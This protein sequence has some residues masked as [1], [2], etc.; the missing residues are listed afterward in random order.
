MKYVE[1]T[2]P[3]KHAAEVKNAQEQLQA[4][5]KLLVSHLRKQK[6]VRRET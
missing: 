2:M 6:F 3:K 1:N 4:Q 5:K